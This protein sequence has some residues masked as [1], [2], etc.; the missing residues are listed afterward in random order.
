MNTQE[1]L[2]KLEKAT[3][4]NYLEK[5]VRTKMR[6]VTLYTIFPITAAP[7]YSDAKNYVLVEDL[8]KIAN[9]N[10]GKFLN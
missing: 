10:S 2:K 8:N 7:N 4:K 9:L 6:K 3:L 5:L 1:T